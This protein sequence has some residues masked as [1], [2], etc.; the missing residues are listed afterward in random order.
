MHVNYLNISF[1]RQL[2]EAAGAMLQAA[3]V[4]HRVTPEL[5]FKVKV[6]VKLRLHGLR[7]LTCVIAVVF[8]RMSKELGLNKSKHN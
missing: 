5:V 4:P 2:A 1:N 8:I 6:K 3:R 7:V